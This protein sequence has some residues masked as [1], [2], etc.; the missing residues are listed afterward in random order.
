MRNKLFFYCLFLV[1]VFGFS[2]TP[3]FAKSKA[4]Q[5]LATAEANKALILR[6]A[7]E[8]NAGNLDYLQVLLHKDFVDHSAFPGAPNDKAGYMAAMNQAYKEW[9]ADMQIRVDQVMA[10]GDRVSYRVYVTAIHKGNVMGAAPTGKKIAWQDFG[11]YRVQEGQLI[12]R[13][14]LLDSAAFMM[15]LGLLK[16]AN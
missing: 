12:E 7:N 3:L 10:E 4:E 14:E 8:L 1:F 9:F 5:A 16:P 2:A 6:W 15:Q 11:F 13:W